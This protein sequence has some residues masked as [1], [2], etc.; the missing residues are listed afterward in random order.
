MTEKITRA[1]SHSPGEVQL[2]WAGATL[3][4]LAGLAFALMSGVSTFFLYGFP[5]IFGVIGAFVLARRATGSRPAIH[6]AIT[7]LRL[8]YA[9]H[10]IW[11][12][13]RYWFTDMQPMMTASLSFEFIDT[14]EKMGIFPAI[15]TLEG[16]IGLMLLFNRF[17]PLALVL[18]V[19]TSM[20]IF[21]LNTFISHT[22]RTI[23]TGPAEIIVNGLMLLG[24]FGY[25]RPFLAARTKPA[26][27]LLKHA[28]PL[29]DGYP[30]RDGSPSIGHIAKTE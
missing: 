28:P 15:K 2:L 5:I 12:S 25:Y 18:E 19:P 3:A 16:F 23:F 4:L 7:A 1:D 30:Q 22:I 17:V 13:L 21:Y 20:T 9:A 10:L 8:Y 29:Q 26:P 6:H 14:L 27:P 24:Y 11:T